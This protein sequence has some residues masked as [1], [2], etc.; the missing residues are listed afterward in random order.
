MHCARSLRGAT[1]SDGRD[2]VSMQIRCQEKP[3]SSENLLVRNSLEWP[4]TVAGQAIA[5][6]ATGLDVRRPAPTV[7]EL[8]ACPSGLIVLKLPGT[9]VKFQA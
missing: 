7:E 5:G 9:P 1:D 3:V 8:R 6:Q 4:Q 2:S